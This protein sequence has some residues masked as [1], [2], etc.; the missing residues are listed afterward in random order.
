MN[1]SKGLLADVR[2][3][4]VDVT[5]QQRELFPFD[6]FEYS[7]SLTGA[8]DVLK[9]KSGWTLDVTQG[10]LAEKPLTTDNEFLNVDL[11]K[12][13][14]ITADKINVTDLFAQDITATGTITGVT[15]EGGS[16]SI[17][18]GTFSVTDVGHMTAADVAITGG[19]IDIEGTSTG[20]EI[21]EG[22]IR[23]YRNSG[24]G[25]SWLN[26]NQFSSDA[27]LIVGD[28][29][30]DTTG[31]GGVRARYYVITSGNIPKPQL[32][33]ENSI[34][35]GADVAIVLG[36]DGSGKPMLYA[37][38]IATGTRRPLHNAF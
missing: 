28:S 34:T 15:L 8:A 19:S 5:G 3:G 18:G 33:F 25:E 14:S 36:I 26:Q 35:T 6:A 27:E 10:V 21:N 7:S 11:L 31:G 29:A 22:S 30:S 23:L 32:I 20:V 37:E 17:G 24:V 16:I 9:L 38:L 12:A 1:E 4:A 13:G 2:P